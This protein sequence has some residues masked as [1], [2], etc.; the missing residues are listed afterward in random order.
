MQSSLTL[1]ILDGTFAIHRLPPTAEVP[2][3]IL[4]QAVFSVT[5]TPQEL[6]LVVREDV[7]IVAD[8]TEPGWRG[9]VIE[10]TLD[11]GM[12]GV[13]AA[14]SQVL[15]EAQISIFAI[16]TYD[17]DYILVKAD[18]LEATCEALRRAGYG[19]RKEAELA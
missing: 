2:L 3:E 17:T 6:S 19:L 5:R 10:G 18:K 11:F 13:L 15:A 12:T 1:A 14:I 7:P 9:L 4:R 16:S 8:K